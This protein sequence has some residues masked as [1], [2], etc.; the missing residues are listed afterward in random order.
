M[1]TFR[2]ST[3]AVVL[4]AF[5]HDQ[6]PAEITPYDRFRLF[7]ECAPIDLRVE[8]LPPNAADI[9]LTKERIQ[10]LAESRLRAER[11][12][13]EEATAYLYVRIGVLVLENEEEGA[14][15]VEVSFKKHLS[16]S[17]SDLS[18]YATTWDSGNYGIGDAG[19]IM[20]SLSKYLDRFVLDYQRVN[21]AACGNRRQSEKP[22]SYPPP[23]GQSP[24]EVRAASKRGE[25]GRGFTYSNVSLADT[26]HMLT[27]ATGKGYMGEMTN[28]SG[29]D[30]SLVN[31]KTSIYGR[32]GTLIGVVSLTITDFAH[33]ETKSFVTV[34]FPNSKNLSAQ[35]IQSYKIAYDSGIEEE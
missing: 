26:K 13:D 19:F 11:L 14:F 10:S 17:I 1:R 25:A 30:Y 27:G 24:S 21:E 12:L 34:P 15:S 4:T 32:G 35:A 2:N 5:F 33:G 22:R 18:S 23:R 16:D 6:A 20:Q 8:E 9:E 29:K 28:S 3:L 7:N 31:F